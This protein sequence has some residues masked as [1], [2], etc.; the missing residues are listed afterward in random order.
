M[1]KDVKSP[2][3][4]DMPF[5]GTDAF[6][7]PPGLVP[8]AESNNLTIYITTLYRWGTVKYNKTIQKYDMDVYVAYMSP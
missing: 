3:K 4:Q 1:L 2:W 5:I 6:Q 8:D 7:N